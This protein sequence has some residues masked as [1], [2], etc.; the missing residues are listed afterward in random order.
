MSGIT[1][2]AMVVVKIAAVLT[3]STTVSTGMSYF[4]S[5][6]FKR[7]NKGRRDSNVADN[8]ESVRETARSRRPL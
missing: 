2:V 8:P 5:F 6:E 3:V 4:S 7:K 1:T